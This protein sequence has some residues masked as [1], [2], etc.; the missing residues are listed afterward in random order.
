MSGGQRRYDARVEATA[1]VGANRRR[2]AG[3]TG[4]ILLTKH[5]VFL[6]SISPCDRSPGRSTL[7]NTLDF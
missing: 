6:Q 2:S 7:P 5:T 4:P 3:A 1:Q